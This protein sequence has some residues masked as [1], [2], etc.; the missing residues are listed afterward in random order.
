[1]GTFSGLD[2]PARQRLG[3]DSLDFDALA[4][5]GITGGQIRNIAVNA[6][7][8]AAARD[9]VL[10]MTLLADAARDELR[11]SGRPFVAADF[12]AW[13]NPQPRRNLPETEEAR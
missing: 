4:K 3:I 6:A 8:L 13:T 12:A 2:E 5:P 1:M 9:G 7:F 11:K 10:T